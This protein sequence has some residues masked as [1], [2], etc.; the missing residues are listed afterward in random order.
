MCLVQPHGCALCVAAPA[1]YAWCSHMDVPFVLQPQQYMPGAAT[2]MCPLCCS[3]SNICLVSCEEIRTYLSQ[4]NTCK[5]GLE[6]PLIVER[7][8]NFDPTVEGRVWSMEDVTCSG[9]LTKLCNHKRKVLALAAFQ[10]STAGQD[11]HNKMGE[12]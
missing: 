6:C 1:I 10:S 9:D 7:T 8:F 12:G 3:P 11:A 4:N 2:W 5:C